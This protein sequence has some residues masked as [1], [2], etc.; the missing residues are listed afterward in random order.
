[1]LRVGVRCAGLIATSSL[2][3]LVLAGCAHAACSSTRV[4]SLAALASEVGAGH[5]VCLGDGSYTGS[6][7][8]SNPSA[9]SRSSD[10]ARQSSLSAPLGLTRADLGS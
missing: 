4:T 6:V 7:D 1:M 2:T 10:N 3:T 5:S 9:I 8:L